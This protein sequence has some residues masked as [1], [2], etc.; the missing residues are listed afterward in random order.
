MKRLVASAQLLLLAWLLAAPVHAQQVRAWLDRD[1]IALGETATLNI[2][3]EDAT[4]RAPDY[5]P[6]QRD[7]GLGGHTS[8]RSYERVNGRSVARTLFAVALEP[9]REG[10][11]GIPPLDVAGS[12]T[13]PLTLTVTA[14]AATPARAG[15]E[16]F[17]QAEADA[18]APYVQQ[19]VGYTVRLYYASPLV[20]GTL[21]QPQPEHATL[22]RVG[23]DLRYQRRIGGTDYSVVERHFLLIPE[24][25]GTLAIPPAR[26]EG[27]GVSGFFD[28]FFGDG[29]RTLRANGPARVLDVRTPPAGAPQPWLPLHDLSV[30]WRGSPQQGRA[31]DAFT[32]TLEVAADGA[33]A[34]QLP[35][36]ELPPLDGAQV[37]ADPPQSDDGFDGGRPRTR[38]V[39]R[40]SIVPSTAGTL[41]I[42]APRITW[43]DVRAGAARTASAEPLQVEVAAGAGDPTGAENPAARGARS[44]TP[45]STGGNAGQGG[46]LRIPGVQ[47]QVRPWALATVLFALAWL[48]TLAWGL[49][50]RAAAREDVPPAVAPTARVKRDG[51]RLK[52]ALDEGDLGDVA[53]ALCAAAVPPAAGLDEVQA[54]LADPRQ[55]EAV[56]SMQRARWAGGDGTVARRA[57]REA[58]RRGPTWAATSADRNDDPLPP[59]YP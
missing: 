25:S 55:R 39:R 42:P 41:A 7:F 51:A 37:F 29:R 45:A 22:Q 31:G 57:L 21:D 24:S 6:L 8:R 5:T 56:E 26:F 23:Q 58:F 9:R 47:D 46:W 54:R 17:I 38:V 34:A 15:D 12:R 33:T 19:A 16:V 3:V 35:A 40:F 14:P 32:V 20:S 36:I 59:L 28:D 43:W 13:A 52:R 44:G 10:V 49:H 1:R 11:I 18:Q 4:A 50:R 53:D 27:T 30:R 48:V 2:E